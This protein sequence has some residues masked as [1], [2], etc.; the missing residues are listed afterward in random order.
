MKPTENATTVLRPITYY[1]P[2]RKIHLNPDDRDSVETAIAIQEGRELKPGYTEDPFEPLLQVDQA[3]LEDNPFAQELVEMAREIQDGLGNEQ[4]WIESLDSY[5]KHLKHRLFSWYEV[6]LYAYKVKIQ[7]AYRKQFRS[8]REWCQQAL[9][10][11]V[12]AINT[13]IRAARALSTLIALGFT[14]LPQSASVAHELS[15]LQPDEMEIAWHRIT[16]KWADHEIKAITIAQFLSDFTEEE[17]PKFKRTEIDYPLYLKLHE[18]AA[19]GGTTPKQLL[20]NIL[21]QYLG[22]DDECLPIP[23]ETNEALPIEPV[24]TGNPQGEDLPSNSVPHQTRGPVYGSNLDAQKPAVEQ[25]PVLPTLEK[26]ESLESVAAF[27]KGV[28][29]A[30]RQITQKVMA[31][32]VR[33]F[34]SDAPW[35]ELARELGKEPREVFGQF[36]TYLVQS[37]KASG[38]DPDHSE[39]FAQFIANGIFRNPGSELNCNYWIEFKSSFEKGMTPPV[40]NTSTSN[41]WVRLAKALGYISKFNPETN[42]VIVP[43]ENRPIPIEK[44]KARHSLDYLKKC[45][46]RSKQ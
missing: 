6:A 36:K 45:M 28:Y 8:F 21:T 46:E 44:V 2:L 32:Q 41:E 5:T 27:N 30:T 23:T 39:N 35:G 43:G 37:A 20:K 42:T 15:R 10:C 40:K 34:L 16:E 12:A 4:D 3:F 11:T 26:S 7:A 24:A 17:L 31:T 29:L 25:G 1:D 18:A 22:E 14:R 9:G 33:N 13:K 19:A 38:K